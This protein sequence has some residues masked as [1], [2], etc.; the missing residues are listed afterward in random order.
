MKTLAEMILRFLV[1]TA[2]ILA[3]CLVV[4]ACAYAGIYMR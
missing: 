3:V 4:V 1:S 2:F